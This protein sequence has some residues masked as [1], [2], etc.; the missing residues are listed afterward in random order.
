VHAPEVVL[1]AL[2]STQ[3][4]LRVRFQRHTLCLSGTPAT[5]PALIWRGHVSVHDDSDAEQHGA[6]SGLYPSLSSPRLE[7]RTL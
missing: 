7:T 4:P 1:A 5:L 3:R 6:S 2:T